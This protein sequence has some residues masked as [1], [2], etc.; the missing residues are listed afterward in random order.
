MAIH[1]D[2]AQAQAEIARLQAALAQKNALSLKVHES[3]VV[4]IYG[5]NKR[6]PVSLYPGQWDR[7]I[8]FIPTIKTKIAG[9]P[10]ERS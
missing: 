7:L 1:Q 9:L 3:G 8:D 2:L 5:L 6:F 10:R 4:S